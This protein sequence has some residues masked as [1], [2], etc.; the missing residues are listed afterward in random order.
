MRL[1]SLVYIQKNLVFTLLLDK[2]LMQT[3]LSNQ[4][5]EAAVAPPAAECFNAKNA[6][7]HFWVI[8]AFW[9]A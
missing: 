8:N 4:S 1:K 7:P 6:M 5:E 2:M 3:F 9:N